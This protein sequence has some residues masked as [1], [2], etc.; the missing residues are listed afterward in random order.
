MTIEFK[1]AVRENV[2][3]L[4]GLVGG[5]K[6]LDKWREKTPGPESIAK[7]K[8]AKKAY[9]DW[10]ATE[11][12]DTMGSNAASDLGEGSESMMA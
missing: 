7:A 6:S 12:S 11:T 5:Q 4:I 9:D 3:L 2:G 1:R 10:T 8:K